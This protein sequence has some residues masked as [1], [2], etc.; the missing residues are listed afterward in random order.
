MNRRDFLHQSASAVAGFAAASAAAAPDR[1]ATR[2]IDT[3]THF[4]DPTRPEGVPWPRAGTPLHRRVLPPD[5][6]AVAEPHGIKET[7]V[8][9]ASPRLEDNAWILELAARERSIVGFVGHLLPESP[10]FAQHFLRFA[11]NPLFRGLR[12]PQTSV[13]ANARQPAFL[14][15]LGL[16][17]E[18]GLSLDLNGPPKLHHIATRIAAEL[19]SLRIILNHVG[20]AGDPARLSPE[21]LASLRELGKHPQVYCKVSALQEQTAASAQRY[22]AAPRDTASYAPILDHCWECFGPTR[23]IYG[24]NWPV[25]EKGG[26]YADQFAIV[27]EYFTAKGPDACEAFF[28]QNSRAAYR[29][30]ER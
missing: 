27:K 14:K 2:I 28:W 10:D 21:W 1:A 24:S 17:A 12:V 16:L 11:A 23:L 3:H 19:P 5:W 22:G 15:A 8:V 4:Y 30:I 26:S 25:C 29:W 7:V 6:R 18:H 13:L 20:S 9:E